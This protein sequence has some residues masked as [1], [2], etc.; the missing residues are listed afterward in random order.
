MLV[1][2]DKKLLNIFENKI[3]IYIKKEKSDKDDELSLVLDDLHMANE[4]RDQK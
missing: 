2:I 1:K 3:F 4:Y